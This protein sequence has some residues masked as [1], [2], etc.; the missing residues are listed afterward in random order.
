MKKTLLFL[1]IIFSGNFIV[2]GQSPRIDYGNNP[3]AGH[4]ATVNGI[5]MYYEVY[6]EGQPL[7]LLHGNGGSIK[8]HA[9]R[10]EH[11]KSKYKV[12][13]VDSRAHG[14]T[15]DTGDSL[16]YDLMAKDI[17]MLLE[18]LK[19]DSCFIWDKVTAAS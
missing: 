5:K 1:L 2:C 17:N 10:I 9:G 4:Y 19:I 12:I 3:D 14:K 11:F 16:T 8:G 15:E 18:S 13:A 7:L 6:G